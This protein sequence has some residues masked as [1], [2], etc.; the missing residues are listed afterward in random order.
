MIDHRWEKNSRFRHDIMIDDIVEM[1]K[2]GMTLPEI[3]EHY[4]VSRFCIMNRFKHDDIKPINWR[5]TKGYYNHSLE[6]KKKIG[7]SNSP[8][9]KGKTWEEI[10]GKGKAKELKKNWIEQQKRKFLDGFNP[11]ASKA[12]RKKISEKAKERCKDSKYLKKILTY[13]GQNKQEKFM[14]DLLHRSGYN[15]KF[16]GDGKVSIDG[17][18]PDFI[19]DDRIIEYFGSYWHKK[20][21]EKERVLFFNKRGYRTLVIWDYELKNMEKLKLRIK[22]FSNG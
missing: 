4:N 11:S 22:E 6:T 16:V 21:D 17:K 9:R 13:V 18:C 2:N 10:Y 12:A 7:N 3:A 1:N 8:Y 5:Y 15:F 20:K 19:L 14:E